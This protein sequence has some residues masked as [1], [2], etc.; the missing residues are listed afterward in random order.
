MNKVR[1]LKREVGVESPRHLTG[2]VLS[3]EKGSWVV[4][5]D[6]SETLC[7]QAVSCLV[8]PAIDDKALIA[9]TGTEAWILAILERSQGRSVELDVGRDMS[10]GSEDSSLTLSSGKDLTMHCDGDM[11][12]S[13]RTTRLE[14][15]KVDVVSPVFGFLGDALEATFQKV[16][17]IAQGLD[18][19]FGSVRTRMRSSF[20]EIE[21]VDQVRSKEI[22]YRA[23]R[24]MTL[25]AENFFGKAKRLLRM[26]GKQIHMG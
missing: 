8:L 15:G 13:A 5:M 23:D 6:G 19:C 16:S 12:L 11:R 18:S 25:R 21:G 1:R 17:F 24:N 2:R 7:R 14:S 4:E 26:D 3:K 9:L 22:D 20:R 10:V